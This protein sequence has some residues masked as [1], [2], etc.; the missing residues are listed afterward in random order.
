M[1][2]MK[3]IRR[4]ELKPRI[5]ENL[6]CEMHSAVDYQKDHLQAIQKFYDDVAQRMK[7]Q[8]SLEEIIIVWFTEGYAED[9]RLNYLKKHRHALV[10]T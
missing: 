1:W 4:D 5:I 10:T 7:D 8:I 2:I 9:F 3:K 6:G